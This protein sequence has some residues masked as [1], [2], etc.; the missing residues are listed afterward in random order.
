MSGQPQTIMK[1]KQGENPGY[2]VC[3]YLEN[4][5][6]AN[7][8]KFVM[9]FCDLEKNLRPTKLEFYF[10]N[11]I[12]KRK[13]IMIFT[14]GCP[15]SS[16]RVTEYITNQIKANN[17]DFVMTFSLNAPPDIQLNTIEFEFEAETGN[18]TTGRE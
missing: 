1:L 12:P 7:N 5:I 2:Y 18:T 4:Q 6:E 8:G 9:S 3:E 10:I 14:Q 13:I 17:G 15:K 11:G 16:W